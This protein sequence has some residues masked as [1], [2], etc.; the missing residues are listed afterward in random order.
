MAKDR[1]KLPPE[2]VASLQ[3]AQ[4]DLQSILPDID[5]AE[6]C[7][8]ECQQYRQTH[9]EAMDRIEQLLTHFGPNTATRRK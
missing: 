6:A 1:I 7:G 3:Q 4:R 9:Q 8:I 2:S 5:G